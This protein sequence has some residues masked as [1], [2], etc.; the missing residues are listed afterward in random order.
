MD[1]FGM[2]KDGW[3]VSPLA[4]FDKIKSKVSGIWATSCADHV[5]WNIETYNSVNLFNVYDVFSL[6][7]QPTTRGRS[8]YFDFFW[9]GALHH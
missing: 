4:W 5:I 6:V 3:H 2:N 9:G 1:I 8:S 7:Q